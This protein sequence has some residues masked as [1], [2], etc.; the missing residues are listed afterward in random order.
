MAI[1]H[2][3]FMRADLGSS[4]AD[5]INRRCRSGLYSAVVS[6]YTKDF[7]KEEVERCERSLKHKGYSCYVSVHIIEPEIRQAFYISWE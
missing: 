4:I 2:D 6:F 5:E 1:P 7:T 3:S